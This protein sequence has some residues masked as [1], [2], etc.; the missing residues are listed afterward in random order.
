MLIIMLIIYLLNIVCGTIHSKKNYSQ[1]FHNL[2]Q[3]IH[4]FIS[5]TLCV[6][7]ID[8]IYAAMIYF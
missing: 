8:E 2:V 6:M 7:K 5:M 4:L 3:F 1:I